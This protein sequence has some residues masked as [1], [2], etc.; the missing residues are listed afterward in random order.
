MDIGQRIRQRRRARG[1]TQAALGR[2]LFVSKQAVSKWET[3]RVVPDLQTVERLAAALDCPPQ[4]LLG[5]SQ[6]ARLCAMRGSYGKGGT[7]PMRKESRIEQW[8]GLKFGMFLHYGLYSVLGRGEWAMFNEP[9]DKDDYARLAAQFTAQRFDGAA[10]AQ[11]ARDAGMKYMVLTTRHHDGF[12]L[13]DSAHS[14]GDFTVMQA[15]AGRDLVR[16]YVQGCRAAGL[17]TGLYYSPMDWRCEGFFHPKMYRRSALAMRSQC[18]E[19]VREL[20]TGY[21]PIDILWYD[22]GEDFWLAHGCDLQQLDPA[23]MQPEGWMQRPIVEDFWGEAELDAMVREAQPGIVV[24]NRLGMRR[25]GDYTT[26]ERVVGAFD[27]QHPWETCDTLSETWGWTPDGR[28]RSP[29]EVLALLT[30]VVTGGGNLLLN[31]SPRPDGSIDPAHAQCLLVVGRWLE[32]YGEAIYD[33]NGGPLRN[34]MDRGGF[35]WRGDALYALLIGEE[36]KGFRLPASGYAVR[37]A[38][39]LTGGRVTLA[40]QGEMR[41]VRVENQA[42]NTPVSVVKLVLDRPVNE[43]FS[44]ADAADFDAF[45]A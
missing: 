40:K 37:S 5:G 38:Q 17:W 2:A 10:L 9:I 7:H 16:D 26:P 45:G 24:N 13:F 6:D 21:G 33:T 4:E 34:N 36:R 11:L 39:C 25:C 19:Q 18:H 15:A 8:R 30:R 20:V 28:L 42:E 23:R 29:E 3:G 1:M 41:A 14:I 35:T 12:C 32:R 44:G 43:A 31:V 22:G 27:P